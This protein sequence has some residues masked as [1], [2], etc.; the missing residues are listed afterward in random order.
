MKLFKRVLNHE[1]VSGSFYIF[2]GSIVANVFAFLL[3]LFLAR[4][5]SYSDYAIFASLLSVITLASIPA[6]SM[7]AVI[8]RF[9]TDYYAREQLEKLK[10]FY[11][12]IFRFIL[13]LSF[14][15]F[16]SFVI[17]SVPLKNFLHLD[18]ASYVILA[19]LIVSMTYLFI[20]NSAFLQSLLKFAFISIMSVIG[21]I[22]KLFA[23]V[24]LVIFGFRAFGGLW[25]VFFMML[26]SFLL[27]FIPLKKIISQQVVGKKISIKTG[28]IFSYAFP[29]FLISLFLT[30][31]TSI[32]VILVKH[33]F[34]AQDAGFYAGV[35]LIGR[36]IFYFTSPIPIVM[37]PLLVK[38]HSIGK[39][40]VNLF[41]LAQVLVILPSLAITVF[42]FVFPDFVINLFL[43]GRDYLYVAPYL[44]I[45]GLYITI[46]S[47]VNVC[48]NFFLSLKK[49]R[50]AV[51]VVIAALSQIVLI[52]FY[53]TN[54]Y[55][56]IGVSLVISSLLLISLLYVFFRSYGNFGKL[57]E[58]IAFLN[59]PLA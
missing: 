40:F 37:F 42:Y 49:T 22:V 31:F 21:G 32:D 57:K 51:L 18:N 29:T 4:N 9:A 17:F 5:L 55:E 23:G 39:N 59:S 48:V 28:E 16:S 47:A 54:F 43:G 13:I 27:G 36:V 8:M 6:G 30:S 46:F 19:G 53:H 34:S 38:R 58:N 45:F 50:I 20:M 15:I 26:V 3:N 10:I 14:L 52:Y 12:K 2:V 25:A 35:S 41:Y 11:F 1:L 56:V 33:F 24:V 7:S 44:G